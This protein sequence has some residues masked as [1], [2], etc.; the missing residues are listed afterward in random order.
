MHSTSEKDVKKIDANSGISYALRGFP[1]RV[2]AV[3]KVQGA[4][5]GNDR[6]GSAP[7]CLEKANKSVFCTTGLGK[8]RVRL[9]EES[10]ARIE[11]A[12]GI[13]GQLRT[14]TGDR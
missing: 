13:T 5:F 8:T 14:Y 2:R 6:R 10:G 7:G 1:D 11:L 3:Q 4:I 12:G 9:S